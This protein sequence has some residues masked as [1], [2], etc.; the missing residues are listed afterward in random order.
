MSAKVSGDALDVLLRKARSYNDFTSE[1]VNDDQLRA[2]YDIMKW[3]PTTA[4]SQPQRIVF[5]RSAEA[6]ERLMPALS[7]GNKKKNY[8]GAVIAILAYDM[9]FFEHLPK[10]FHN[11]AARSWYETTPEAIRTTAL[12]NATLQ[13]A[14]FIMAA[15]AVGL[16][17]SPMSGLNNDKVDAEF[18]PDGRFKSNFICAVGRGDPSTLPPEG[19]RFSFDEVCKII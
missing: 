19:Y 15:R 7:A 13:G 16:D 14:Y 1:P 4:N 11:P 10:L 6:K 8:G 5:L 18:F 12:R 3:G 2:L 9:R 17:C